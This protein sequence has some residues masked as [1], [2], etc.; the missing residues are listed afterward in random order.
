MTLSDKTKITY[1]ISRI[2][3]ALAFEWIAQFLDKEKFD[4]EFILINTKPSDLALHLNSNHIPCKEFIFHN[5]LGLLLIFSKILV[6]LIN[7]PTQIVH[8]HLFEANII[9]LTCAWL[10]RIN[11]RIFTR[12]HAMIHHADYPQG[13]KWD[14]YCNSIA[15][16]IIAISN[17][18]KNILIEKDRASVDKI[19]LIHHGFDLLEF[20]NVGQDRI[21]KVKNKINLSDTDGPVVGVI[22]RYTYWKGI[23]YIIPAFQALLKIH[24]RAVLILA[25]AHGDYKSEIKQLL[26]QLPKENYKEIIFENDLPALYKIFDIYVHTPIDEEVEAFGQTY[27][28][29]L[30]AGVPSIFTLSGVAIEFIKNDSNAL[31]VPFKNSEEIFKAIINLLDSSD[32]KEQLSTKGKKDVAHGFTIQQNIGELES[33]YLSL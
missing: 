5:K 22:S 6:R 7:Q 2:D 12:H 29:A 21:Q 3:K 27:V 1:I 32:Q 10:L 15:T 14:K 13:L 16:D 4:L 9:G 19:S 20:Q 11:R 31:V 33:L 17:N 8:T 26:N 28:E 23:Q 30:A 25:N 24:P 18:V